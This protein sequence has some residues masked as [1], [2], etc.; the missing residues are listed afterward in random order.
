M[1]EIVTYV[2]EEHTPDIDNK[3]AKKIWVFSI[4]LIETGKL[5]KAYPIFWWN[6]ITFRKYRDTK[7]GV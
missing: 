4:K 5:T 6:K 7:S 1:E 2:S 3:L